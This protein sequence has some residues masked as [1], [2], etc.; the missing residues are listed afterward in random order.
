M[1]TL[2]LN[3]DRLDP[4]VRDRDRKTGLKKRKSKPQLNPA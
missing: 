4:S 2:T 1:S 3:G